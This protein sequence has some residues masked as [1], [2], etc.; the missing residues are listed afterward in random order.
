MIR[1]LV[2]AAT[3]VLLAVVVITVFGFSSYVSLPR[4]SSP[5]VEIPVVVVSTPYVGVAPEDIEGLVTIPLENELASLTDVKKMSSSSAEGI[6]VVSIEFEPEVDIDDALQKVRD[7]VSRAKAKLPDDAEEPS[8]NEVSFSDV[9]IMLVTIGGGVDEQSLKKL[10]EDLESKVTRIS[11]VLEANVTGGRE[12]EIQVQ[13]YPQ[14]LSHYALSMNDVVT[15]IQSEN[16]N[17]PGGN[18]TAG[19]STFLLRTPGEFT[20]AS[21]VEQVAVKRV[22]D[23]PVFV[24]DLGRVEDTFKDRSTYSRMNGRDS[25]T[26]SIKKRT[27]AN[28]LQV[29]DD[30]KALVAA[31]AETWPEGVSYRILG[32]QSENIDNMV[33][34]LQNNIITALILVVGVLMIFMGARNSLFVAVAIPLSMLCSFLVLQFLGYTLNM[35]VLFSLILALGMLVDNGIVIVENI[36]RHVEMG[37]PPIEAAVK[38]TKEV[39]LAVAASTATTVAAFF[40]LVFWTGI[41]GQFMGFL[42]KT[43]IIVLTASLFVA[44]AILPVAASRLMRS[45]SAANVKSAERDEPV[46]IEKLGPMMTRYVRVLQASIRRRY[47]AL[48]AGVL[49]LIVSF[50]VYGFLN[51]GV[52][53]FPATDPDRVTVGV[54]LAEGADLEATD[55]V[56]RQMEAILAAEPNVDVYVAEVGVS[57]SANPLEGTSEQSNSGRITVDF[58]PAADKALPGETLRVENTNDTTARLRELSAQIVGAEITV[59]PE[60][61]GPP[62]GAPIAVEISGDDFH[63][64]GAVAQD[65]AREFS[66]LTVQTDEGAVIGPTDLK[67]DYRV[68]RPELRLRVNRGAAKR[69]GVSTQ[70]VGGAVRT[71]IAGSKASALRDG[72]DEYDIT[73]SL[74]PE[75]RRDLQ[76]ILSMRLPGR[77][78][79]SPNTFPVPLSSVAS[80]EMAGGAGAIK[81]IDQERVVTVSG[82]VTSPALESASQK[83]VLAFISSYEAP[84]GV[85]LRLGGANDEQKD[86]EAFLSWAF[87]LAV[88][89]ILMVL[90]AQFDSFAMPAIILFTVVLSLVG[91]LWGLIITGTPFG[92]IMTGIGII[93]LAGVV[94]NNA[95]VLLDYVQQLRKG[96]MSTE[97]ALVRAGVTRFRPV[98][99]T[100]VTTTLGLIPMAVGISVDFVKFRFITGS[101]S[102][103]LWGPMAIAVIFGLSF[104]TVLTLVMVPTLYAIYEDMMNESKRIFGRT[105]VVAAAATVGLITLVAASPLAY[106]DEGVVT[107]SDAYDAA[108]D[109]NF[110]LGLQKEAT[111]QAKTRRGQ[112]LSAVMPQINL[113]AKYA[114]NQNE[115]ILDFTE[116]LPD[117]DFPGFEIPESDPVVVQ[118]KSAWSGTLSIS[119]PIFSGQALPGYIAANRLYQASLA[120]ETRTRQ[121][122]RGS[123]AQAYY[124]L[125]ATRDAVS[126]FELAVETATNSL[127]LAER[128]Y[129]AGTEEKRAVLQGQLQLARAQRDLLAGQESLVD[130]EEQFTFVTGLSGD[131]VLERPTI[132]GLP[133]SEEAALSYA[134]DNRPD[135]D[136]E[137]ERLGA[138]KMEKL[139][140][141][142]AWAPSVDFFFAEIYNQIPG[143]V[144]QNFQWQ[145]GFNFNW[146]LL[147]GGFRIA[148]SREVA[149]QIRSQNLVQEQTRQQIDV[150]IQTAWAGLQRADAALASVQA[151]LELANE[152]LRLTELSYEAGNLTFLDV[153]AA[154]LA[155]DNTRLALTRE[156]ASRDLAAIQ[157]LISMGKL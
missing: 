73:V 83:A 136:A 76:Q 130:A 101:S 148:K 48:G 75:Y 49:T 105:K 62:V 54:K 44:I 138:I 133:E 77:E 8:V 98:M 95:I 110:N 97:D 70:A 135:L 78:D 123:V 87:G 109:Y 90:V 25:V 96:G 131:S 156:V 125:L 106:G 139:A 142:L 51:H 153:E 4:E 15:A 5:D 113:G 23:R 114:V 91:V 127:D 155:R 53:F 100:A 143:F 146:Q 104:A 10:G 21:Q 94:V 103:Q 34:E 63:A 64:L 52:E 39:A 152:N 35:V 150:D 149:S 65:L 60:A 93:S 157:L 59:E 85:N 46:E 86:A 80:Y 56:V 66:T 14:R 132:T 126:V 40:P 82:D 61:L 6:S 22:G 3:T 71:A 140:R 45:P 147:N 145:L 69:I 1:A 115:V 112:A 43:V 67:H 12:R 2:Q 26:V 42:P 122:V 30:V 107:L 117:I 24:R 18:V 108:E 17:I 116:N 57:A 121:L 124:T 55:R 111:F 19:G 9:P 20:A 119:Q 28:I 88:A 120:D 141:D 151:E 41:M 38:G 74:A 102:A 31:E 37:T 137:E 32:D 29:A 92:I 7:R 89:L 129:N 47:L 13:V 36:Y 154:V 58:L 99:L 50:V 81:H 79:T 11:G 16:V 134:Y 68:G 33:S 144:P 118:P 84:E 27:G 128:R 72:E